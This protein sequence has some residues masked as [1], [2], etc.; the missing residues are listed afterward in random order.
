[1]G[2][3]AGDRFLAGDFS[4]LDSVQIGFEAHPASYPMG[5]WGCFYVGKVAGNA[6][7]KN[8]ETITSLPRASS[9]RSSLSQVGR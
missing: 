3:T 8:D 7:V 1:M 5:T 9:F 6:Q 4:L 2:W